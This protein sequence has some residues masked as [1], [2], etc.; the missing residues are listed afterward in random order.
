MNLRGANSCSKDTST[1]GFLDSLFSYL[2][3][4]LSFDDNGDLGEISL[5]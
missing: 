1:T 4:D 3:E 5:A 2:G